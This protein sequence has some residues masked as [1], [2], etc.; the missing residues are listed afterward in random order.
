LTATRRWRRTVFTTCAESRWG[1]GIERG[2]GAGLLLRFH[3][4]TTKRGR[5]RFFNEAIHALRRRVERTFAWEDTFKRLLLRFE[6]IQQ[7][8]YAMKLLGD[9]MMNLRACCDIYNSQPVER[10][11]TDK[12]LDNMRRYEVGS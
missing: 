6:H 9:T 1:R 3:R 7:Q 4:H 8:H 12:K 10:K 5:K 2:L 11:K